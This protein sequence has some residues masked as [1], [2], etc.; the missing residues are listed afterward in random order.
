MGL[1]LI[2]YPGTYTPGAETALHAAV[3]VINE[4]WAQANTKTAAFEAKI[5]AITDQ[6]TGWLATT[7]APHITGPTDV[8]VP[9]IAE[10]P[11]TIPSLINVTDVMTLFDTKY[12]E[13]VALLA[14]KFVAF[15]TS[16][17]PNEQAS[18][19]AA[20]SWLAAAVANP[21]GGMP[22]A[23]AAQLITDDRDRITADAIRASDALIATFAARRFPLLPGAAAS[24]ILQIQ[25]TAQDGMADS[26]RKLTIQ[27]LE[28]MKFAIEKTVSMRQ[29]AM[30]SAVDYIKALASG[31]DMAS[32]LINTG[33]DAQSK[34]IT[35]AAAFYNA[36]T[37]ASKA[38]SAVRQFNSTTALSVA[39]KN[40][41]SD[42]TMI[43]DRLKALLTECS[44]FAQMATSLFNNLHASSGTSYGVS[45][46]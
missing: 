39:E 27:S 13:L 29:I 20:E 21:T 11:V 15:R 45:I 31:P 25:Q 46:T 3:D 1:P 37:D 28:M 16:Y 14:D 7:A 18:Y 38:V 36:R 33:Y 43:E 24:G 17:F 34:L 5:G 2:V 40:Q 19:A 44:A 41:M 30:N 12:L 32:R 42:L 26:S 23:V 10:P 22:A 8:V 6:T 9:T 35:S 4:A